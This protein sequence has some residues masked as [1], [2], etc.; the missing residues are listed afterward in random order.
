[1]HV[2]SLYIDQS[3]MINLCTLPLHSLDNL[4]PA[5]QTIFSNKKCFTEMGWFI[6][7]G[8]K[9][10][11][12]LDYDTEEYRA[13]LS[14][15]PFISNMGHIGF[16]TKSAYL[17]S[18]RDFRDYEENEIFGYFFDLEDQR[19]NFLYFELCPPIKLKVFDSEKKL[20][21]TGKIFTHIYP[22]GYL[23]LHLSFSFLNCDQI[24][25]GEDLENIIKV[26]SPLLSNT[27]FTVYSKFGSL[28]L[29]ELS[30]ELYKNL[31][32]SIYTQQENMTITKPDWI[33][34]ALVISDVKNES[35]IADLFHQN[36]YY[37]S[38]DIFKR[39]F[40]IRT[41]WR[42]EMTTDYVYCKSKINFYF[43]NIKRDAI[44][45]L[46]K[47]RDQML[48]HEAEWISQLEKWKEKQPV[49]FKLLKMLPTILK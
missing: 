1:M 42:N 3:C 5:F 32:L 33:A 30:K 8:E 24:Q 49:I 34:S 19:M 16:H 44:L 25:S 39:K 20:V 21:A 13:G 12:I 31:F 37:N 9:F 4:R 22:S 29:A 47:S 40:K 18:R 48:K 27:G 35:D 6:C 43:S 11:N 28:S 10:D 46:D 7:D 2:Q 41:D 38:T 26:F 17:I 45:G 23:Y 36:H 15:A 14:R